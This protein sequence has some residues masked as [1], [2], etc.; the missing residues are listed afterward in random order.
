MVALSLSLSLFSWHLHLMEDDE[1]FGVECTWC[2]SPYSAP[3]AGMNTGLN[4]HCP[5]PSFL[6]QLK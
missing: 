6:L 1:M 2:A 3:D 4:L 5:P